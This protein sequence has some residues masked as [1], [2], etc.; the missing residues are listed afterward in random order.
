MMI[1]AFLES[2]DFL[3]PSDIEAFV[4][5]GQPLVLEKS[6][7]FSRVG[8]VGNT[9][10]FVLSGILR[11]FYYADNADE[12]TYCILFPNTMVSAYSS[13]ITGLPSEE[14][15]QAITEVEML[16]FRKADLLALSEGNIRWI[17]F[18]RVMAERQFVEQEERIFR[19]QRYSAQDRYTKLLIEQPD[20][21]QHIPQRYLASY[22]GITQ[23]H[24]SRIRAQL[25]K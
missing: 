19:L 16:S 6:E 10:G 20:Y 25:A 14:C 12:I 9:V 7:Y 22:L 24:L 11:S 4:Q 8:E 21:V 23:R 2:F 5:L 13:F 15:I 17:N 1:R 18:M 3:L